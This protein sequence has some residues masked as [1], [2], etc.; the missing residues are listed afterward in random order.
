MK[1]LKETIKTG[2][3]YGTMLSEIYVPNII[4]VFKACGFD[5]VIIDCE[6]GYFDYIQVAN[7]L[8][9]A[10]GFNMP[11]IVR[12][13]K[14][15]REFVLKYLDMGADGFL[16][17]TTENADDVRQLVEYTKYPPM[18]RRGISLQ[19]AHT[20][21]TPG[22]IREY[23]AEANRN[24]IVIA[25]M[26]SQ[27]GADG[28]DDILSV[29]GV[30][31]AIVG[32]NDFTLDLGILGQYDD[33]AFVRN[34]EKM[35]DAATRRGKF[36]GVIGSNIEFLKKWESR[37]MSLLS[38]NSEIGMILNEGKRGLSLLKDN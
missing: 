2:N 27:K 29:D 22:K 19:R 35:V 20:D 13:S 14:V 1:N 34:V 38:W 5:F 3:V 30:D 32:P 25:Q 7:L 33:P 6:H 9:V 10:R 26:E 21:Y 37:G 23:L 31:G 28:I 16:L 36:S 8:A 18:G 24:T 4:R 11:V 12:I 15:D 17:S